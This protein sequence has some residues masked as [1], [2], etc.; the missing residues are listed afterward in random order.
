M[1]N[2]L[3]LVLKKYGFSA[4]LLIVGLYGGSSYTSSKIS[5]TSVQQT[6]FS[7]QLPTPT[8]LASNNDKC[9]SGTIVENLDCFSWRQYKKPDSEGRIC[10]NFYTPFQSPDF[11]LESKINLNFKNISYQVIISGENKVPITYIISLGKDLRI[12]RFYFQEKSSVMIGFERINLTDPEF[13]LIRE[14]SKQLREAPMLGTTATIHVKPIVVSGNEIQ[15]IF[16]IKY[17]SSITEKTIEDSFPYFLKL[18]EADI[19]TSNSLTQ[20]G[21]G[22][23]KGGCI[24]PNSYAIE[25]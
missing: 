24:K 15:Y 21:F 16:N 3:K 18:P 8:V 9:H 6:Q 1:E 19:N 11:W 4:L 20:L 13:G 22:T 2:L 10:P 5:Q 12:F 7:L 17:I 23:L 25:E 14:D